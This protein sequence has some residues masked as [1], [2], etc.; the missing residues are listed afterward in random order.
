ML[1]S[2][3]VDDARLHREAPNGS[4]MSSRAIRNL[5]TFT[6]SSFNT[7]E[8]KPYFIHA[9]GFGDDVANWLID[10]LKFRDVRTFQKPS[11]RDYGWYLLFSPAVAVHRLALTF[12]P[13]NDSGDGHW[14]GC[15]ERCPAIR[16]FLKRARTPD[17][18]AV[19]IVH[20]IL[21]AS[22]MIQNIHWYFEQELD[23]RYRSVAHLSS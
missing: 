10:E 9:G 21:S 3:K 12:V 14:L 17:N 19:K 8:P 16:L 7:T 5:V 2:D 20:R 1:L 11:Q 18:S 13:S 4:R 22:S 15:I 6:S 23:A